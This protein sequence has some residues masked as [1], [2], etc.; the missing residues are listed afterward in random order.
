VIH[1]NKKDTSKLRESDILVLVGKGK[2]WLPRETKKGGARAYLP[3]G[4][5]SDSQF[6]FKEDGDMIVEIDPERNVVLL[7]PP[8]RE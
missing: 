7:Y 6:P 4:V 8:N 5:V 1:H 3:S 2:I